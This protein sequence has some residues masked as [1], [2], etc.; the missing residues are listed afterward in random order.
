MATATVQAFK[1]LPKEMLD[2]GITV[3][4]VNAIDMK[5][6]YSPVQFLKGDSP[7]RLLK[8]EKGY[9]VLFDNAQILKDAKNNAIVYTEK[10]CRLGRARYLVNYGEQEKARKIKELC[11]RWKRLTRE[12]IDKIKS[13]VKDLEDFA[14]ASES[15]EESFIESHSLMKSLNPERYEQIRVRKV[16]ELHNL[17]PV[18]VEIEKMWEENKIV[19]LMAILKIKEFENPMLTVDMEN[20]YDIKVLVNTFSRKKLEKWDGDMLNRYATI[21]IEKQYPI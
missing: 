9:W 14:Q 11:E 7:A 20:E 5:E 16:F 3:E 4:L 18:Y 10:E 13:E 2:E 17:K 21:E 6:N 15:K 12:A 19:D 1:K 8:C